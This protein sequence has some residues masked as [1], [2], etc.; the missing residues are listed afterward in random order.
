MTK[1][2]IPSLV[3]KPAFIGPGNCLFPL[4]YAQ[5]ALISKKVVFPYHGC[6]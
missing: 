2:D 3:D 6:G 4:Q 1:G 5:Q